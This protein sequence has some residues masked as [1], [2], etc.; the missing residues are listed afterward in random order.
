MCRYDHTLRV[1]MP[2]SHVYAFRYLKMLLMNILIIMVV[3]H[4]QALLQD[5]FYID[6]SLLLYHIAG[7]IIFKIV[8]LPHATFDR[9]GHHVIACSLNRYDMMLGHVSVNVTFISF[10]HFY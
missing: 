8:A 10:T 7:H 2:V 1:H 9:S 6:I 5:D 4:V 3:Y